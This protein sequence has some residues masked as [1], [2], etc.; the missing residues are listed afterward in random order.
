MLKD[1]VYQY[2]FNGPC[3]CAEAMLHIYADEYGCAV[4]EDAYKA[5][6]SF[7]GGMGCGETCGALAGCLAALGL[8]YIQTDAHSSELL[9]PACT[10]MPEEFV[11]AFGGLRCESLR[12]KYIESGRRCGPL[13]EQTAEILEHVIG[14]YG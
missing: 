11:K 7:G 5:I 9:K 14:T 6:G 10:M 2:F 4:S 3:N 1:R 8:R 12:P 13:L